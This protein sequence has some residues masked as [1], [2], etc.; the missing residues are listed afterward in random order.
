MN[1]VNE[2]TYRKTTGEAD[3]SCRSSKFSV[4][5]IHHGTWQSQFSLFLSIILGS[6][7]EILGVFNGKPR[8]EP[9]SDAGRFT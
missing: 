5:A 4:H 1:H 8:R 3:G 6:Y 9:K 2:V 7:F